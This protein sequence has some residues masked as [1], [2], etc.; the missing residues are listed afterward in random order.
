MANSGGAI[1]LLPTPGRVFCSSPAAVR[2]ISPS[3]LGGARGGIPQP[4]LTTLFVRKNEFYVVMQNQF[5]S[6]TQPWINCELCVV[7][8]A[9]VTAKITSG[10]PARESVEPLFSQ[11]PRYIALVFTVRDK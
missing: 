11:S 7:T 9:I 8:S 1:I 10:L 6:Y 4:L 2:E 5:T 3:F